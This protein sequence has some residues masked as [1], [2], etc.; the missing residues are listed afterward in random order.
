MN[1]SVYNAAKKQ[2]R[3]VSDNVI[4]KASDFLFD[5]NEILTFVNQLLKTCFFTLG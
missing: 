2:E 4:L 3:N 1:R 5:L